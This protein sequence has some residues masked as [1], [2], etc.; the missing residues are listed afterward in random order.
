MNHKRIPLWQEDRDRNN[1]P[2]LD[3]N[4]KAEVAVIGAGLTGIT[5]AYLLASNGLDVILIDRGKIGSGTSGHT[6][7]KITAQ[8]GMIYSEFISHFGKEQAQLYFQSQMEAL[9]KIEELIEKHHID[10]H[11]EKQDAYLYTN[12]EK[13]KHKLEAEFEAYRTLDI[14]GEG[15]LEMP[16]NFPMSYALKMKDQAQFHPMAYMDALAKAFSELGGRIYENTPVYD[17][18]SADHRVIRAVN[19][20]TIVCDQVVIATHFPFYEGEAFY[21][22]RMYP[23]RSYVAGFT[24]NGKYPGGMYLSVDQQTQSLRSII[25]NEEEIWLFGGGEHKT[26]QYKHNE[27]PYRLLKDMASQHFDVKE[28]KYEWSAQD[29]TTLDKMPYIGRLNKN[30]QKI[31]LATGYRKWGMTNSMV[32]ANLITDMIIQNDNPYIDLYRPSRFHP[33]PDL[34]QFISTNTNVAKEF[35]M[36]KIGNKNDHIDKLEINTAKKVKHHGQTIGIYKDTHEKIHAVDTTCTHLGC[37]LNWNNTE[38]TWDCPCH[39][40]RFHYKGDVIEGPAIK[41]LNKIDYLN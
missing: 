15:L 27:E 18:D 6:T 20:H 26:G 29:Y 37:E 23:S 33:D 28:W 39:G 40:S 31:F 8:H 25:H 4:E 21:S 9:A 13:N 1:Y 14:D 30:R 17:I 16:V 32:A 24:S 41:P 36:G 12:D 22:G 2:S 35:I 34:K 38:K 5:T 3:K 19:Q 7:A 11:F 10:C